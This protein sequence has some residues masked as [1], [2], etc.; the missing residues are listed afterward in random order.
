[1]S[2]VKILKCK[3]NECKAWVREEFAT[4]GQTCPMCSGPMLRTMKH[5]PPLVKKVKSTSR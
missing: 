3:N 1:M 5:L 2:I 4:P